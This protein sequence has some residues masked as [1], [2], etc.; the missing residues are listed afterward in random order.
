[1]IGLPSRTVGLPWII[2]FVCSAKPSSAFACWWQLAHVAATFAAY[3][4]EDGSS[5]GSM[6]CDP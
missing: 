4:V 5:A 6:V 3:T 2:A 1:M